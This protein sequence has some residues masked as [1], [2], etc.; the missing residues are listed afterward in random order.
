MISSGSGGP[1]ERLRIVVG[2]GEVAVDGRL[3]INDRVEDAALEPL[4][5]QLGEEALN[6]IQ[7]GA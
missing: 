5:G 2:L 3:K 6:R 7:P 4:P 1:G